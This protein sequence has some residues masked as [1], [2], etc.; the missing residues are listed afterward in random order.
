MNVRDKLIKAMFELERENHVGFSF[1]DCDF[2]EIETNDA[3]RMIEVICEQVPEI[4]EFLAR[5]CS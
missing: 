3:E 4:A 1:G 5:E 2:S